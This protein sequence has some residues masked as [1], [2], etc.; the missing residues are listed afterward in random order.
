MYVVIE[1][2]DTCGKST[3][4]ELLRKIYPQALFTKEP[5]GTGLGAKIRDL[6][7]FDSPTNTHLDE[8]AETLLFLADRAQHYAEVLYKHEENLIIS[9][10]SLISGIAYARNINIQEAIMLNHFAMRTLL[11]DLVCILQLDEA[12]LRMR[13]KAK[14]HDNIESRGIAYLLE[15]QARLI[16]V[17]QM[18]GIHY[19]LLDSTQS[20]EALC[21]NISEAITHSLQ[22]K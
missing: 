2:I 16:E 6:I 1:G 11:P 14:N 13:L 3:Q 22:Q 20:K 7:L 10:R 9:D 19:I 8:R 15:I 5:G 21:S 17:T 18:L 4:I 12:N